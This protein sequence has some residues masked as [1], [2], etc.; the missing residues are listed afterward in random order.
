[1]SPTEPD[2]DRPIHGATNIAREAGLFTKDGAPDKDALY[3]KVRAGLLKGII[4]KNGRGLTSTRRQ[5][6]QIGT[7]S[8]L[9]AK[10]A[11]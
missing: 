7:Q 4:H 6:Q 8:I 1:M 3:Y 5:L 9:I 11:E 2:L 10:P